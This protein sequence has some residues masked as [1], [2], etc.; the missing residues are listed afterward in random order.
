MESLWSTEAS[1]F[2]RQPSA[3]RP[4]STQTW[5]SVCASERV[6]VRAC[7]VCAQ[8]VCVHAWVCLCA[9]CA[10]VHCDARL[11]H[12]RGALRAPRCPVWGS[13]CFIGAAGWC[14]GACGSTPPRQ[15][16]PTSSFKTP[17]LLQTSGQCGLAP[18][19]TLERAICPLPGG[20][21][22][23]VLGKVSRGQSWGGGECGPGWEGGRPGA[24]AAAQP[25]VRVLPAKHR[26]V[27]KCEAVGDRTTG[28]GPAGY[29]PPCTFWS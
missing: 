11:P 4:P 9:G 7:A 28:E 23:G 25:R 12:L 2:A 16:L 13:L 5:R 15:G 26:N 17:P 29:L 20:H 14:L 10:S 27:T 3:R 6:C 19:D 24:S 1:S 8:C 21:E 18:R 22:A